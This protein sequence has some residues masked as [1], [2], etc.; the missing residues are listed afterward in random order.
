MTR[1]ASLN[2]CLHDAFFYQQIGDAFTK[3][4]LIDFGVIER[5]FFKIVQA[6][7]IYIFLIQE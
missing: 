4:V 2:W 1:S 6:I 5:I 7:Y 3:A